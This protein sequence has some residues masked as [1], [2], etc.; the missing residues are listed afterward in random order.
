M[1]IIKIADFRKKVLNKGLFKQVAIYPYFNNE[2]KRYERVVVFSDKV[3]E[4]TELKFRKKTIALVLP[5]ND[6]AQQGIVAYGETVKRYVGVDAPVFSIYN[7]EGQKLCQVDI[8][9]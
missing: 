7:L 8:R 5:Y 3:S 6:N 1:E 9:Q 2:N 4:P